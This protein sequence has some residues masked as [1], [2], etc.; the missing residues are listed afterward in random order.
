MKCCFFLL[1]FILLLLHNT[2]DTKFLIKPMA[3]WTEFF[4][5]CSNLWIN[6]SGM[7]VSQSLFSPCQRQIIIHSQQSLLGL[8]AGFIEVKKT[9][10][11][12]TCFLV[13]RTYLKGP[14]LHNTLFPPGQYRHGA[15][16]LKY[17]NCCEAMSQKMTD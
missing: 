6:L 5:N 11:I 17:L 13:K 9:L 14:R 1:L 4:Q 7:T 8:F 2:T 10:C 12:C 15:W 3:L 16:I